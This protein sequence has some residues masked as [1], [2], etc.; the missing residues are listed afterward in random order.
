VN[1]S[2]ASPT[3]VEDCAVFGLLWQNVAKAVSAISASHP[4]AF[5]DQPNAALSGFDG[6]PV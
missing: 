5:V 3:V 6:G 1:P 4:G 2:V